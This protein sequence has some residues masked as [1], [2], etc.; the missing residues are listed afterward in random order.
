MGVTLVGLKQPKPSE[1]KVFKYFYDAHEAV[2]LFTTF[3]QN[4]WVFTFGGI[5]ALNL[6]LAL[7]II[8]KY[9]W[10]NSKKLKLLEEVKAFADGVLMFQNEQTKS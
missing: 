1:R 8:D 10:R 9:P 6:E 3:L 5:A 4:Q 7:K 2:L